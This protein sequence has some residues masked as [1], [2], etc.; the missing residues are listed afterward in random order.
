MPP[1]LATEGGEVIAVCSPQTVFLAGGTKL[2][3]PEVAQ[4]LEHAIP[5]GRR[6]LTGREQRLVHQSVES[7]KQP[8]LTQRITNAHSLGSRDVERRWKNRK[9]LPQSPLF[10]RCQLVAPV[11]GRVQGLAVGRCC[12]VSRTEQFE[13]I[14]ETFENLFHR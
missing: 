12:P 4:A 6:R 11:E 9:P 3:Q 5:H 2:L 1:G 14:V 13:A 7:V 8:V 10:F